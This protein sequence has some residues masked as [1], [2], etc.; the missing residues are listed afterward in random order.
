MQ[1]R[2]GNFTSKALKNFLCAHFSHCHNVTQISIVETMNSCWL[3]WLLVL[4]ALLMLF[5]S[6]LKGSDSNIFVVNIN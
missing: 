4:R 1:L 2:I 6:E 3:W 5:G